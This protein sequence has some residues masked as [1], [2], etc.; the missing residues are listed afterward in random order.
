MQKESAGHN[1]AIVQWIED[2]QFDAQEHS[3][4]ESWWFSWVVWGSSGL[5]IQLDQWRG[6]YAHAKYWSSRP[7][8]RKSQAQSFL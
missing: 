1:K 2:A 3:K 4:H 5:D 6:Q 7:I 8:D